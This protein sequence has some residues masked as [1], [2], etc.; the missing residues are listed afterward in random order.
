MEL[1]DIIFFVTL[2]AGGAWIISAVARII[3]QWDLH[4]IRKHF[5]S[6]VYVQKF[7]Q[8]TDGM[9]GYEMF[10][11][12]LGMI[13]VAL[14]LYGGENYKWAGAFGLFLCANYLT[15]GLGVISVKNGQ[16]R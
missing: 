16:Y 3:I 14:S 4:D 11:C 5:T 9:I 15:F 7:N 12:L 6:K 10:V 1:D 13:L 2:I 8:Y